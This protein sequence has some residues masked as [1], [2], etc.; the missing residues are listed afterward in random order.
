[1]VNKWLAGI[2]H[3]PIKLN[4]FGYIYF[5]NELRRRY[6][7]AGGR[8]FYNRMEAVRFIR[9]FARHIEGKIAAPPKKEKPQKIK[10]VAR[11]ERKSFYRTSEWKQLRYQVL[12]ARGARCECCGASPKDGAVMNVDH[13]EPVSKAW[14]KRL[15]IQN[16]Q[17]L[18]SSCNWGKGAS[19]T[20]DWR[21]DFDMDA[22]DRI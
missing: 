13:I 7:D 11:T 2:G 20:T 16:L 19:D 6:G 5:A 14:D 17:V 10:R 15:N 1:M 4:G 3:E 21:A 12:V 18:C 22:T 9:H 8:S